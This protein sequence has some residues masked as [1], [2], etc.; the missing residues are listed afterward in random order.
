VC[1]WGEGVP[2]ASLLILRNGEPGTLEVTLSPL[3]YHYRHRA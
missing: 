1:A 2:A 3:R